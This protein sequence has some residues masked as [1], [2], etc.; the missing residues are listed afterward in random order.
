MFRYFGDIM[1]PVSRNRNKNA[2]SKGVKVLYKTC[3]ND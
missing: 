2:S 1:T 3:M